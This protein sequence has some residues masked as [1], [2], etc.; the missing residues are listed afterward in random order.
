MIMENVHIHPNAKIGKN[1][2]IEPFTYIAENVEIGDDC[3]IGPNVTIFDYVKIGSGCKVFPGAVLGAIPQDLKFHGEISWVEIGDRTTIRECATVNRGTEASG[4]LLTRI[5]SDCLIM[6]YVH[7][8]HDCR[9]GNH[10]ILSSFVGL[11]GE[12]DVDDWVTMGG[13]ALVHQFTHI[14]AHAMVGGGSAVNKDVPP[15][16]LVARNPIVYEGINI[17]GLRRHG[18]AI[19][20][21]EEIRDMYKQIYESDKNVGDACRVI[22]EVFPDSAYKTT[23]LEF[24]E[25]SSRGI[26]KR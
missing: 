19:H 23:I 18:F 12:T 21:I 11:A 8:A 25:G 10:C 4:K 9:I 2:V 7:V 22:R 20:E 13:G 24:I 6:S 5:G 26:V 16:T 15:F 3:W 14:G 17:V 1:V